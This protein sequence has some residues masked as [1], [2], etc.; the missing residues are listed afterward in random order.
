M[1][2][3]LSISL[4]A[5]SLL[6]SFDS[7]AAISQRVTTS[8]SLEVE[9]L[10][11]Q[12][13]STTQSSGNSYFVELDSA[14]PSKIDQNK[15]LKQSFAEASDA[16]QDADNDGFDNLTEYLARTDPQVASSSSETLNIT[17]SFESEAMPVWLNQ[18]T[19][20]APWFITDDFASDGVQ[21]IRSGVSEGSQ[22]SSF[23]IT[24]SFVKGFL[25][26]D[27]KRVSPSC[28]DR[29]YVFID[30]ET[31]FSTYHKSSSF[32]TVALDVPSGLHQLK[33]RSDS[34]S[35][36]AENAVWLDNFV[37]VS[38]DDLTDTDGDQLPDYWEL[39]NGLDRLDPTDALSDHDFDGLSALE[40]FNS[41]TNP[42]SG[43][44]DN[45][46][47]SDAYEVI[48]NLLPLD[49]SDADSD[50]DNDNFS[51][52]Q[53]FYAQSSASDTT[54]TPQRFAQLN[55]S[56]E[57]G[58][59]PTYFTKLALNIGTWERNTDWSTDGNASLAL[60]QTDV[61]GVAGFAIAGIFSSGF[62]IFDYTTDIWT[63]DSDLLEVSLNGTAIESEVYR[64]RLVLP[65]S[66]GYNVV[67]VKFDITS[68]YNSQYYYD[69]VSF[70]N[71][72]WLKEFDT[73]VD[74]NN[75]GIP[76]Y[77]EYEN[78]LNVLKYEAHLDFDDDGLSNLEEFTLQTNP[79]DKDSDADGVIDSEDS[80][81]NDASLGENQDPVF[82]NLEPIII[83]ATGK[84]TYIPSV[85]LPQVTDNGR[86]EKVHTKN[87]TR[88]PLGEHQITWVARD[89]GGNEATAIQTVT[90]VDTTPPIIQSTEF[91][92]FFFLW[93]QYLSSA[94][95]CYY[96]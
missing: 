72:K 60:A 44:S 12:S 84:E 83:E 28:C 65:V 21:S 93:Q 81:P 34:G 10:L 91:F 66:D 48:H 67:K 47:M 32:T 87:G 18:V 53:E 52:I 89:F 77:W 31:V 61:T 26:F 37:Y 92:I 20:S 63:D 70:D 30:G 13:S 4:I 94:S 19:G 6:N 45:D 38:E 8:S 73:S 50:A 54:S 27:Y 49:A 69:A 82:G 25:V 3:S 15:K 5:F 46:E 24:G 29:L 58:R 86:I 55:E 88:Y 85:F 76:D 33:F 90:I 36:L 43:D 16:S 74:S 80:H 40:E 7:N 64:S 62:I 1:Y 11:M 79:R 39:T 14:K 35:S 68:R 59:L 56:F 41:G 95:R 96:K 71:F 17:S 2:K 42:T 78:G 75:N 23:D 22:F 57:E 51:N 9:A